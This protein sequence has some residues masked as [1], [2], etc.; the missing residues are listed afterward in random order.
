ML[1]GAVVNCLAVVLGGA[2]GFL[3]KKGLSEKMSETIMG[4]LG[5]CVLYIGID[6]SLVGEEILITII[7]I[8][9]G[10]LV[11]EGLDLHGKINRLGELLHTDAA[12]ARGFISASLLF[13]VGAMAIVGSLQSGLTGNH[14]T[15]FAKS[16][17]DGIAALVLA[18]SLGAG[19]MLSGGLVLL[20]EG[21]LTLLAKAIEPYLTTAV[22]NEVTCVGSLL[23][24][25]IALNMLKITNLKIMNYVPAILIVILLCLFITHQ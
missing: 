23:I 1:W 13:C 21:S 6:G 22:I 12:I 4:G 24:V 2:L 19:V 25:G 20:Y 9:L 10:A 16:L 5:L 18:S 3:L 17:I 14:E 8:V 7:S 15:L 11:G